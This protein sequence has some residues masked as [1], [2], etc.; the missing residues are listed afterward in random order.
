MKPVSIFLTFL[1]AGLAFAYQG[2]IMNEYQQEIM[3]RRI[4]E[5]RLLWQ[6]MKSEG[7]TEDTVAALDFV[8]FSDS[9]EQAT[10]LIAQLSENY[11]LELSAAPEPGYF[12]IKGTTRP[13]GNEFTYQ[14]WMDWVAFMV[15]VGFTHNSVF[16]AWS[17][18]S[19]K[20]KKT[21]SSEAVEAR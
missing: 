15:G 17:V 9:H 13:Y 19:P 4:E 18:Y 16:S 10:Q 5:A 1:I 21:W 2:P 3:D 12:L 7:F 11:S 8:F 6:T 14:Q 20:T